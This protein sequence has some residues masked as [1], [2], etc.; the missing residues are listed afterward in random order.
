MN[1]FRPFSLNI[2]GKLH[3]FDRP[4]VMGIVNVTPDSFFA[5]SRTYDDNAIKARVRKMLDEGADIID[6]GAYSSRPGAD[7]VSVEEETMRIA[8][9]MMIIRQIAPDTIISVDTFRADVARVA[10]ESYGADIIND[11]SGGDLDDKMWSTAAQL[12]APYIL[13]HMRGT[14]ATMQSMTDYKNVTAD[15][16]NDLSAKLRKLRLAGVADVIIDPGFGFSFGKTI[17]QNFDLMRNLDIIAGTLDAP[18]LVGISRKSMITKS[19][20]I[21]PADALAGTI[22]LNTIALMRGASIIRVHDV[23]EAVATLRMYQLSNI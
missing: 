1:V 16:V 23:A 10:V 4:L 9:G 18:L 5:D 21:S 2:R 19:L 14:P 12:H 6:I 11:I 3:T 15:V 22:A 7:E 13:M 20:N 8:K 17:E